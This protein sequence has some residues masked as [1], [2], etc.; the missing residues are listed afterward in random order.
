[1]G[2]TGR[3]SGMHRLSRGQFRGVSEAKLLE[4]VPAQ[5]PRALYHM[6]TSHLQ[7]PSSL[8]LNSGVHPTALT[9][10]ARGILSS[11]SRHR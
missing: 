9:S 7:N 3:S 10:D 2:G 5:N 4:L 8:V 11:P 1:M 6:L